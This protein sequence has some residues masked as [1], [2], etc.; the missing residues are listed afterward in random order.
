MA[1]QAAS[2]LPRYTW[3]IRWPN[4]FEAPYGD[5]GLIGVASVWGESADPANTSALDAFTTTTR[6]PV[7][8]TTTRRPPVTTT[9]TSAST[10]TTV[11]P[12]PQPDP[13]APLPTG[14]LGPRQ[15]SAIVWTGSEVLVMIGSNQSGGGPATTSA[16][17]YNPTSRTWR[18]MPD[19]PEAGWGHPAG[20]WTGSEAIIWGGADEA[21]GPG[22]V[23]IA[24]NPQTNTWRT[25]PAGPFDMRT[26]NSAVWTGRELIV[27]G[28][29]DISKPPPYH[30]A[31]DGA[32]YN[33][34]TDQ[35]RILA[36][37]PLDG[38]FAH[39][40]M[41]TGTEMIVWGGVSGEENGAPIA[42]QGAA[43][44]PVTDTWRLIADAPIA[45][46]K[47]PTAEWTGTQVL[48]S[49]GPDLAAYDPA[50]D[51]WEALPSGPIA[52]ESTA[53]WTGHELIVASDAGMASYNP[54]TRTW[55]TL[56]SPSGLGL[57]YDRRLVWTGEA[58]FRFSID[59]L[60]AIRP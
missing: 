50:S 18:R 46:R 9:T 19:A 56:P 16:A 29:Y 48:L 11:R 6:R 42:H 4:A 2:P 24:Y 21:G 40:A 49:S 60:V 41:W 22:P 27:W 51:R 47:W 23:D 44:N 45:P 34:T 33:P 59:R 58:A 43:Y 25:L 20:V 17:A 36:P 5:V 3:H 38:R 39:T 32:A 14:P 28:G 26:F 12:A 52:A 1:L 37:S 35:W 57:M 7:T 54:A 55:R 30:S 13:G 53:V 31:A 8:T 10:T 15:G